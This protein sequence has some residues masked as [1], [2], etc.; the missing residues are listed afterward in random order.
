MFLIR[1]WFCEDIITRTAFTCCS[2]R[3]SRTSFDGSCD[4][5][6][7]VDGASSDPD[8]E[9]TLKIREVKGGHDTNMFTEVVVLTKT[10]FVS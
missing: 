2:D 1:C 6:E 7:D 8:T 5:G 4:G 10:V 3:H 9:G